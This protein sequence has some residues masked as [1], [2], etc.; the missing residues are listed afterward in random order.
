MMDEFESKRGMIQV[1][2]DML[3]KNAGDEV[4]KSVTLT[5]VPSS[6]VADKPHQKDSYSKGGMVD[7]S[8]PNSDLMQ[9]ASEDMKMADGGMP[10]PTDEPERQLMPR[11]QNADGSSDSE[12][13]KN[14]P[15]HPEDCD[16]EKEEDQK[17]HNEELEEDDQYNNSSSFD[18][19]LPRK[20]KK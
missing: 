12:A 11:A 19:F 16:A 8:K 1:L 17:E 14:L 18:A 2:M 7:L 20:K 13:V 10:S 5:P 15:E 9:P 6:P 4:G 3:K